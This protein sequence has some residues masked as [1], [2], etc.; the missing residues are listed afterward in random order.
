MKKWIACLLAMM[1][2]SPLGARAE[3]ELK[4]LG[5]PLGESYVYY[6]QA[7]GMDDPALQEKVNHALVEGLGVEALLSRIALTMNAA[8]PLQADYTAHTAGEVL[9]CV[10]HA[11]GPVA[12]DR[13]TERF[14]AVNVDL[15]TGESITFDDLFTDASAAVAAMEEYMDFTVASELSAHLQN[16]ELLPLPTAFGLSATGM[17]F[18]YDMEKLST[19]SDHAGTVTILWCELLEHL[20]LEEGSVLSRIGA[21]DMLTM[22]AEKIRETVEKGVL[23][24]LP[25]Q[26]G[27]S[28]E[29]ELDEHRLLLD[30]DLY[31]GGRMFQ[32]E[33][34]AF[35]G[36]WLLSDSLMDEEWSHSVVQ[37][38]R[39]DRLNMY[40]LLCGV[41]TREE[42]LA[43]LGEA[44]STV[45]LDWEQADAYR[46]APGTSDYYTFGDYRLRLHADE[47]GVLS[48]VFLLK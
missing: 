31:E 40:G 39:A 42:Y 43:A 13:Y 48:S 41:T 44:D 23:P 38:V 24:G 47:E 21:K 3:V 8:D 27:E 45:K 32:L 2:W 10:M 46:L 28:V 15:C 16:S 9:S 20:R 30:P 25:V 37:G 4:M 17:T 14:A 5:L 6:P 35:R 33:D 11:R 19:L 22:N 12:F 34:G 26:L 7:E 29:K 36:A 18:Y 1:L